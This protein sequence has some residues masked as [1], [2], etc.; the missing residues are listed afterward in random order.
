MM[1]T[2]TTMMMAR[3]TAKTPDR[4]SVFIINTSAVGSHFAGP[5]GLH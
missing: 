1:M 5:T 4:K 2:M 3:M